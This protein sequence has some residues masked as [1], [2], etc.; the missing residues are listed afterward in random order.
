M[1]LTSLLF[2]YYSSSGRQEMIRMLIFV[3]DW[4]SVNSISIRILC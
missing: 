4:I 1:V 2:L 3:S